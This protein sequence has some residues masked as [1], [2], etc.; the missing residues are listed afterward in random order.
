MCKAFAPAE[1]ATGGAIKARG[2]TA[3]TDRRSALLAR[4]DGVERGTVVFCA[5]GVEPGADPVH[6]LAAIDPDQV[7]VVV[8]AGR[9]P[10]DTQRWVDRITAVVDVAALAVV[11]AASTATPHTVNTLGIPVGWV[12]GAPAAAARL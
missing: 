6:S 2:R 9:K 5:F 4:A 3:L 10:E 11:G 7:W 8:D 1:L 12:D